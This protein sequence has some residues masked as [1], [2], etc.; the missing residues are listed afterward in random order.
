MPAWVIDDPEVPT[1]TDNGTAAY[2][3][4]SCGIH[5]NGAPDHARRDGICPHGGAALRAIQGKAGIP[6]LYERNRR[7]FRGLCQSAAASD[8]EGLPV[9]AA[10]LDGSPGGDLRVTKDPVAD[11]GMEYHYED[12]RLD[13]RMVCLRTGAGQG[14]AG[15]AGSVG[16]RDARLYLRRQ[17]ST[18]AIPSGTRL[19]DKHGFIVVHPSATPGQMLMR[20]SGVRPG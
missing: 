12:R 13:A 1:G 15:K 11:L 19:P 20:Q 3:R 4:A 10:P 7:R 18:R 17:K 2:W 8:L 14:A 5:G 9:P 16:I 6:R